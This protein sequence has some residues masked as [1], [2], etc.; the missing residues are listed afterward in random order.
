M[1]SQGLLDK[2]LC[3][4]NKNIHHCDSFLLDQVTNVPDSNQSEQGKHYDCAMTQSDKHSFVVLSSLIAS[5]HRST[6]WSLHM[7]H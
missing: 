6:T 1:S 7:K 3:D 4:I 5:I 2:C